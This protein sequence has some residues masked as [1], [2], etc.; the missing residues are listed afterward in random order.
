MV[1]RSKRTTAHQATTFGHKAHDTVNRGGLQRLLKAKFRN[2]G[3]ETPGK[4]CFTCT[5]RPYHDH[6]VPPGNRDL[7]SPLHIFLPANITEIQ[8]VVRFLPQTFQIYL[9]RGYL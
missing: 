4:H 2:N 6:I 5:W 9:E 8:L 1:G 7:Y 3:M